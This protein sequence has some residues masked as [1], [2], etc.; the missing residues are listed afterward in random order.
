MKIYEQCH[1]E[2]SMTQ[3]FERNVNKHRPLIKQHH[4]II[5]ALNGS[6]NFVV[7]DKKKLK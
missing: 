6:G 7:I 2:C 5:R 3:V 1:F 4:Y